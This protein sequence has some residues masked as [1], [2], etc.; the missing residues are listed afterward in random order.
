[1][2]WTGFE[3][4]ARALLAKSTLDNRKEERTREARCL[5]LCQDRTR[6]D[7]Q[8]FPKLVW[9][10]VKRVFV[11]SLCMAAMSDD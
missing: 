10:W 4:E 2:V 9:V 1:M 7:Q 8:M 11:D 6:D 5:Q 3:K